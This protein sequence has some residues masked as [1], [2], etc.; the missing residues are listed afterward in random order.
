MQ[1]KLTAVQRVFYPVSEFVPQLE[2][3]SVLQLSLWSDPI[4]FSVSK[5][6]WWVLVKIQDEGNLAET[7]EKIRW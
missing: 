5:S 7:Q 1:Y 2:L 3:Y 4:D 6:T